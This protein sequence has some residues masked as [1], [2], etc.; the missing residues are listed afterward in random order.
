M[1]NQ[2]QSQA[3]IARR[4]ASPQKPVVLGMQPFP[5]HDGEEGYTR[6]QTVDEDMT[7]D[8]QRW[9]LSHCCYS[10]PDGKHRHALRFSP[11]DYERIQRRAVE[12]LG[13]GQAPVR[14]NTTEGHILDSGFRIYST[15]DLPNVYADEI[16]RLHQRQQAV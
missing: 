8:L 9:L 16:R 1:L 6:I 5:P 13:Y 11:H 3:D 7:R 2:L 14:V 15:K 10:Q 4:K 12:E